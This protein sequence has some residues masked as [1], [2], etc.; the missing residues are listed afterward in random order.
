MTHLSTLLMA[1]AM[2]FGTTIVCAQNYKYHV[3]NGSSSTTVK[4]GNR[5]VTKEFRV[6]RFTHVA[7]SGSI[8]I[9][10]SQ[11]PGNR[12]VEVYTSDN[13]LDLLDIHVKGGTLH[14][15]FKK[16]VSVQYN[17][18]DIRVV[19]PEISG[20]SIAGSGDVKV[21][22]P[23]TADRL[24]F[25][26]NGS[27]DIA[28][29]AISCKDLQVHINGSGDVEMGPLKATTVKGSIAGSGDLELKG[30]ADEAHLTIAGSG[31]ID[32][33]QLQAA[34]V[35]AGISGSGEIRCHATDL[36]KVSIAGSGSVGYKGNPRLECPKKNVYKLD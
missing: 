21:L 2:L 30:R 4:A 9:T 13:L 27:G 17:K 20:F 31:D 33:R 34:K 6:D 25:S 18:L 22:T 16:N 36:L 11:Q 5:Y 7:L 10:F 29:A 23:L 28:C 19:S 35:T 3:K 24:S 15:G 26:I 32:A 12:K 1:V 14:I 8:D